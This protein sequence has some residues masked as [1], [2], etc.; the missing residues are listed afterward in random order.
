MNHDFV[1]LGYT[2]SHFFEL[3]GGSKK[4]VNVSN[5]G[6][7]CCFFTVS[8]KSLNYWFTNWGIFSSLID[9]FFAHAWLAWLFP[10]LFCQVLNSPSSGRHLKLPCMDALPLNQTSGRSVSCWLNLWP[11]AEYHIQVKT[12]H[13][14]TCNA[15]L[16]FAVDAFGPSSFV[17]LNGVLVMVCPRR[18][19]CVTIIFQH[20]IV[21]LSHLGLF[22][23]VN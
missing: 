15:L 4:S 5:D 16:I 20:A 10:F 13:A 14:D 22:H 1:H 9:V 21:I 3:K 18:Q 8:N 11:R 12:A 6:R 17:Q 2:C 23:P 7:M 19:F